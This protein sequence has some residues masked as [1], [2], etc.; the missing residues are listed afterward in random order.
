M[1]I[2]YMNLLP[3]FSLV[4]AEDFITFCQ[5]NNNLRD[6]AQIIQV[7]ILISLSYLYICILLHLL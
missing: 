3:I 7:K 1:L 4:V 5:Y 2:N 6:F